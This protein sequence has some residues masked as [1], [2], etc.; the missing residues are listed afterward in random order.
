[1]DSR[2]ILVGAIICIFLFCIA[3]ALTRHRF[4]AANALGCKYKFSLWKI[5]AVYV[6][7]APIVT[8]AMFFIKAA[9]AMLPFLS[10]IMGA[11]FVDRALAVKAMGWQPAVFSASMLV[12]ISFLQ[13]LGNNLYAFFRVIQRGRVYPVIEKTMTEKIACLPYSYVENDKVQDLL[14]RV[15]AEPEAVLSGILEKIWNYGD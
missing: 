15:A 5:T 1:M 2:G 13:A 8:L 12:A 9:A 14:S 6:R 10:V 11:Q 7:H 4:W 3:E